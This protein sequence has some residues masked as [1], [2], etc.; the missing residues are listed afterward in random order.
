MILDDV[1]NLIQAFK[2]NPAKTTLQTIGIILI[3]VVIILTVDR[4]E[5]WYKK[6]KKVR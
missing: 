1:Y 6:R 2:E 5:K 4:L 3:L